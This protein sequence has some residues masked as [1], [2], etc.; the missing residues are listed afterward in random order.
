[1]FA[2]LA[3]WPV[4]LCPRSCDVRRVRCCFD[5]V[6]IQHS[7]SLPF[8]N[9]TFFRTFF[10]GRASSHKIQIARQA[11]PEHRGSTRYRSGWKISGDLSEDVRCV[12][13]SLS[14]CVLSSDASVTTRFSRKSSGDLMSPT[15]RR[16]AYNQRLSPRMVCLCFSVCSLLLFRASL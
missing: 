3:S 6:I 10:G 4:C 5:Y 14:S 16:C 2:V 11:R 12:V 8:Q 15:R 9:G 1:M 7:P 13:L